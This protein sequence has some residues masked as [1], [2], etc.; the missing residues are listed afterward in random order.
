MEKEAINDWRCHHGVSSVSAL[1]GVPFIP[2]PFPPPKRH[3]ATVRC[4]KF[5]LKIKK[6]LLPLLGEGEPYERR[7]RGALASRD[8]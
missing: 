3:H 6:R 7:E 2:F 8:A 4:F 5:K 1:Q